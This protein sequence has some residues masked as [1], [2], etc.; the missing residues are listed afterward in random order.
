LGFFGKT[1]SV[2]DSTDPFF[3]KI[4]KYLEN[5]GRCNQTKFGLWWYHHL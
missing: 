5:E 3:K 2:F 4:R 1:I